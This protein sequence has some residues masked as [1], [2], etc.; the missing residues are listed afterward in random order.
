MLSIRVKI[1]SDEQHFV[2]K[3]NHKKSSTDTELKPFICEV[4]KQKKGNNLFILLL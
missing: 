1:S 4:I 2:P 3:N